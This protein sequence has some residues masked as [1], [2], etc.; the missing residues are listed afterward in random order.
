MNKTKKEIYADY[1]KE[2]AN[3]I[4]LLAYLDFWFGVGDEGADIDGLDET[5]KLANKK[6]SL[7]KKIVITLAILFLCGSCFLLGRMW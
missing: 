1:K 4:K 2:K 7:V 3:V 5:Y 6:I